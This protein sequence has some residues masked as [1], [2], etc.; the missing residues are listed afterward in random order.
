M[1]GFWSIVSAKVSHGAT[2][3]CVHDPD[4]LKHLPRVQV[5]EL[6]RAILL[7]ILPRSFIPVLIDCRQ[8]AIMNQNTVTQNSHLRQN[9]LKI[10]EVLGHN[11]VF[12]LGQS[13]LKI[14]ENVQL[15]HL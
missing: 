11:V 2:L 8:T 13:K 14:G 10:D 9:T 5:I 15:P 7:V 12:Y 3:G 4:P 1:C 6:A